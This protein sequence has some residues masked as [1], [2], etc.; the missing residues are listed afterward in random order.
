VAVVVPIIST[1]DNRGIKNALREINNADGG[2]RKLEATMKLARVGM[3][4]AAAGAAAFAVKLGV[5]AVQAAMEEEKELAALNQTLK[6]LGFAE[7]SGS[8]NT[9]IDDLQYTSAVTDSELR[10][11]FDRLVRSTGNV[12]EAQDLLKLALDASAGSGKS[13]QAVSEALGRAADGNTTALGKLG[14]GIDKATLATGTL[15]D[16]TDRM[17]TLFAGQA[18]AA[19]NTFEGRMK[20]LAIAASELQ[21]A[22]GSGFIEGFGEAVAAGEG[23]T[24]QLR[25]LQDE[26]ARA[27][28]V[29]GKYSAEAVDMGAASLNAADSLSTLATA[30]SWDSLIAYLRDSTGMMEAFDW[31]VN[32]ISGSKFTSVAAGMVSDL[33]GIKIAADAAVDSMNSIGNGG[34]TPDPNRD[35]KPAYSYT[36]DPY[37]QYEDYTQ[38]LL[39]LQKK[40]ND[41]ARAEAAAAAAARDSARASGS[42]SAA[43]KELTAA[44]KKL[45]AAYEKS[46]DAVEEWKDRL[47]Q[48]SD[49]VKTA[50]DELNNYA[51]GIRDWVTSGISLSEAF[52]AAGDSYTAIEEAYLDKVRDGGGKVT[53]EVRAQAAAAAKAGAISRRHSLKRSET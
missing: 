41:K 44:Q 15:R 46:K 48:A 24:D 23:L 8:V 6:N 3:Y 20:T 25:E 21:E 17:K 13:L 22:F 28:K 34:Y 36:P 43:A 16:I 42:S 27:G 40:I 26:A 45:A 51:D 35:Y 2:F 53:D 10:P 9:F 38:T 47:E 31:V 18:S 5:D 32:A 4:A 1:F 29:A 50:K 33:L 30:P 52:K 11:A 19:A 7:A 14:L 39:A 49:A 12:T 37:N